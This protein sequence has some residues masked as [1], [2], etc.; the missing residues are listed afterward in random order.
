MKQDIT[1]RRSLYQPMKQGNTIT[2]S[3]YQQINYN[4]AWNTD[5]K[6]WHT[7]KIT[8]HTDIIMWHT[9]KMT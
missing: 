9:N 4:I 8:R 2:H 5:K 1:N 7:D 6:T 3:N